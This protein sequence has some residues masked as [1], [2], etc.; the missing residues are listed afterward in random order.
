MSRQDQRAALA[1]SQAVR[2][3][4]MANPDIL[5]P[6]VF[7]CYAESKEQNMPKDTAKN[8]LKFK[9]VF[10]DDYNPVFANGVWGG[11]TAKGELNMNFFHERLPLPHS[12]VMAVGENGTLGQELERDPGPD[13]QVVIRYV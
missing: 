6:L 3:G 1:G 8:G 9:F 11:M 10:G 12:V 7:F 2:G 4:G 5:A 13:D